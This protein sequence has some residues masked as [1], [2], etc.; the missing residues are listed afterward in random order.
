[1]SYPILTITGGDCGCY[2]VSY[3]V[4][5][6]TEGDWECYFTHT[7]SPLR[8]TPPV[9]GGELGAV[10]HSKGFITL[11]KTSTH[12]L[13][14]RQGESCCAVG[15]SKGFITLHYIKKHTLS[16]PETGGG[17]M[18]FPILTITEVDCGCYFTH[19][20]SPLRGTPPVS[21]G[22]LLRGGA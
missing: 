17:G 6:I 4:L 16:P 8:G 14:L 15:R 20:P 7:P 12:F 9:S 2:F 5:T 13:P 10:G 1:M 22:E 3:L 11:H 21:G 18:M 19:T